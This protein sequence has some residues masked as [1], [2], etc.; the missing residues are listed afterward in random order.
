MGIYSAQK[1]FCTICGSEYGWTCNHGFSESRAC[2]RECHEEWKW[3]ET[4]SIMGNSYYPPRSRQ[5]GNWL[6]ERGQAENHSPTIWWCGGNERAGVGENEMRNWTSD[7]TKARRFD[8]ME[9]A[10][11]LAGRLFGPSLF[12]ATEHVFIEPTNG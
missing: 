1:M 8:S 4:L 7:A 9:E 10:L 11:D 5:T 6:I 12:S 3:R 2:S